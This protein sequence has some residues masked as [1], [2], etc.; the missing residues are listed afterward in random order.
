VCECCFIGVE[1]VNVEKIKMG[2]MKSKPRIPFVRIPTF[3]LSNVHY[4]E[5]NRT[6][7][8]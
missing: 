8:T 1:T 6:A 5:V 2:Y 4:D 3:N 7:T